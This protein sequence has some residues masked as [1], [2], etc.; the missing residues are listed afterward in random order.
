MK[1]FSFSLTFNIP[2]LQDSRF[3]Q[4]EFP[5]AFIE[6]VGEGFWWSFISMT[7]VG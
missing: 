7:T 6:G 2:L 3:N 1:Y 5:P 4:D